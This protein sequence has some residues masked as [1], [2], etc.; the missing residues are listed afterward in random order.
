M[1]CFSSRSSHHVAFLF[2]REA[3][4]SGYKQHQ[5]SQMRMICIDQNRKEDEKND[6][7]TP[8]LYSS[9]LRPQGK[10]DIGGVLKVNCNGWWAVK[11]GRVVVDKEKKNVKEGKEK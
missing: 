11:G 10:M 1:Y 9:E 4:V 7:V 5:R 8:C 3:Q 6:F 2:C